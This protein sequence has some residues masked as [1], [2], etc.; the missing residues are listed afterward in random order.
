VII[1]EGC[2]IGLGGFWEAVDTGGVGGWGGVGLGERLVRGRLRAR[3]V[4]GN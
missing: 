3:G 4:V 2:G 1:L